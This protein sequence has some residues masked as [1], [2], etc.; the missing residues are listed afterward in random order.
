VAQL[1][2]HSFHADE[3]LTIHG[4]EFTPIVLPHGHNATA[5]GFLF[6]NVAYLSDLSGMLAAK[7]Q[8]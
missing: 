2:F 3:P 7:Q 4:V 5:L 6:G 1:D 8:G